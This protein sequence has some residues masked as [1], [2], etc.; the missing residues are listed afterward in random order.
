MTHIEQPRVTVITPVYNGEKHLAESIESVLAQ[1]Y[2]NW[3]HIIVNN[4]S[5]DNT[6]AI[7][8]QFA[9][10]DAR[11]RIHNNEHFLAM[12][13]NHNHAFSLIPNESEYCKVLHSDDWL[14]PECIEKMVQVAETY[15]NV[16]IVSSYRLDDIRVN[17][18]GLPYPST[19]IPGNE[20]CRSTLLGGPYVFG[21]PSTLLLRSDLI[22]SRKPFYNEALLHADREVC[23]DILQES[24]FGFVHQ[25]L[26]FTRRG[27]GT[28]TTYARRLNTFIFDDLHTLI[29]YGPIYLSGEDYRIALGK[30]IIRYLQFLCANPLMMRE[31]DF[32]QFHCR[33]LK[34]LRRLVGATETLTAALAA[35]RSKISA[36]FKYPVKSI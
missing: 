4:C 12:I 35:V 10:Q 13:K 29:K 2:G 7:A 18:D 24:D 9:R 3:Q 22:R 28:M 11:I 25:V 19:C 21:S 14:F 27:K 8:S 15:P 5:T 20:L 6:L 36:A 33:G 31:K 32:R 34:E 26:S 30:S 17:C 23:F 16:G 1:T